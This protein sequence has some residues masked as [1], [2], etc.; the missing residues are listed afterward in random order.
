VDW[1]EKMTK[2]VFYLE[3]Q[4]RGIR[5]GTLS[6]GFIETFKVSYHGSPTPL[7][8]L[9][10]FNQVKGQVGKPDQILVIPF[11]TTIV[12]TVA[13]SLQAAK[14]NAYQANPKTVCVSVPPISGE[15]RID[16]A[17]HIKKLGE[18]TKIAIRSI[19]QATRK[20]TDKDKLDDKVIQNITDKH[21]E[22]IDI[23]VANKIKEL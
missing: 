5:P 11:D 8:Q 12:A 1:K 17:K 20:N 6:V 18:E 19:R 22:R 15:Q 4:L 16:L 3:E 21:I 13:N 9:A 7:G 2:S 14:L 10:S 23:L